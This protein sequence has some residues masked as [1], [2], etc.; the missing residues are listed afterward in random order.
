MPRNVEIKARIDGIDE[1]ATRVAA[2]A[3]AGPIEIEQDD[4][5]FACARGR[6]KLRVIA[7]GEGELIFYR[8]DDRAGPK[9]SF[10]VRAP[11]PEPESLRLALTLAYG[12]VG[13]VR[14]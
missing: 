12:Q 3:D 14:K 2:I 8:R 13:R 1:L 9:E 10:Y 6:L 5:F 11:A 4:T 7:G